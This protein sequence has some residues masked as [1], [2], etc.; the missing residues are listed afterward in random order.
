MGQAGVGSGFWRSAEL[1]ETM[2]QDNSCAWAPMA[3]V[4]GSSLPGAT[5]ADLGCSEGGFLRFL[6][7]HHGIEQGFGLDLAEAAIAQARIR[8]QDRPLEYLAAPLP[9][10][11]WP[12]AD[13]C[14]SHELI[15]ILP[16]L[17][18][19]AEI[20]RRLLRP[21]GTYLAVTS[22]HSESPAKRRWHSENAE[23]LR[24]PPLR[25]VEDYVAP[26]LDLR[27]S[28]EIG[29]LPVESVSIHDRHRGV[30]WNRLH[31][32]AHEKVVFRFRRA[33]NES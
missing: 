27:F 2:Q 23:S 1:D 30:V 22:V 28:V 10:P 16:D 8:N 12:E 17:Y 32:W 29:L 4:A 24:L 20:I 13:L 19:H 9:A 18:E 14:F 31:A 25:S 7:D 21:G 26:F 33:G 3:R 5:V 15:Y 6:Y 11:S